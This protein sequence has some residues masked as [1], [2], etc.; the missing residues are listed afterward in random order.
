MTDNSLIE[1]LKQFQF[2][3]EEVKHDKR[4]DYIKSFN[5]PPWDD[6]DPYY[7]RDPWPKFG[8]VSSG[9]C[10]K[11]CWYRDDVIFKKCSENDIAEAYHQMKELHG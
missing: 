8:G 9:I 3:V 7:L 4:I 5:E 11:W 10:M 2:E 6:N 1:W